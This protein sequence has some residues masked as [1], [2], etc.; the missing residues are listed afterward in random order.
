MQSTYHEGITWEELHA[1]DEARIS[2]FI[3]D[4][5]VSTNE[6]ELMKHSVSPST[7]PAPIAS[8]RQTLRSSNYVVRASFGTP[9]QSLLM[10]VDVGNDAS[11]VPCSACV[12]CP[13]SANPFDFKTSST[14]GSVYCN[15]PLCNQVRS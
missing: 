4:E 1:R 8:G 14:F 12:G 6:V 15:N 3:N 13:S 10:A 2:Y 7:K 11:W 5:A 9:P